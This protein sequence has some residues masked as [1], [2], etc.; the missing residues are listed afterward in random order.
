MLIGQLIQH[1]LV[2]FAE[3]IQISTD[4]TTTTRSL[5]HVLDVRMQIGQLLPSAVRV[6]MSCGVHVRQLFLDGI[7][8]GAKVVPCLFIN[9]CF[10][11][12]KGLFHRRNTFAQ[13]RD[14]SLH[15]LTLRLRLDDEFEDHVGQVLDGLGF[16]PMLFEAGMSSQ[17]IL[18]L[19]LRCRRGDA[20][21][22][23]FTGPCGMIQ[24]LKPFDLY[25]SAA[26]LGIVG[27]LGPTEAGEAYEATG[28]QSHG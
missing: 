6:P 23:I 25:E 8:L 26:F 28:L 19:P 13:G 21:H 7:K 22:L 10:E 16:V 15:L 14:G 2:G 5:V 18:L 12:P 27:L 24:D 11:I 9:F 20:W 4:V 17:H 1:L 3:A